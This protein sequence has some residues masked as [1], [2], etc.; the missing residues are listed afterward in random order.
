MSV[1]VRLQSCLCAEGGVKVNHSRIFQPLRSAV[2]MKSE[3]SRF[4]MSQV[5][6]EGSVRVG[7]AKA[8][9]R[10]KSLRIRRSKAVGRKGRWAQNGFIAQS[11]RAGCQRTDGACMATRLVSFPRFLP[12]FVLPS[13]PFRAYRLKALYHSS[14]LSFLIADTRMTR[15]VATQFRTGI[16][17]EGRTL[18]RFVDQPNALSSSEQIGDCQFLYYS[19]VLAPA[20][21]CPGLI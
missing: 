16:A 2:W 21:T 18:Y 4:G 1:F 10:Q 19:V 14:L 3:G 12:I 5:C 7:C 9:N 13:C 17:V 15:V 11:H 8:S 20:P 6:W